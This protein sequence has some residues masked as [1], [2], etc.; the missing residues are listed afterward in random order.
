MRSYFVYKFIRDLESIDHVFI[1]PIH[2]IG[3]IHKCSSDS[4]KRKHGFVFVCL[5]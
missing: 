5:I 2:K 4:H 1:N 3:L